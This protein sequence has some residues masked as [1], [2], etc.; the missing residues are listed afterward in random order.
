VLKANPQVVT[1]ADWNNFQ[2][3]SAIEDSYSWQDAQGR[4]VP[5]LYRRITRAYSRLRGGALVK[6]E[7]YRDETKPEVYLFDGAKLVHQG[8]MPGWAT[9]ILTPAGML[10]RIHQTIGE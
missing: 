6:G 5:D 8:A 1:I 4:A 9:V 10:D 2:E 3:E 7:F